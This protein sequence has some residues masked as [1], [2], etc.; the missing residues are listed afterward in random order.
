MQFKKNLASIITTSCHKLTSNNK[1]CYENSIKQNYEN[2]EFLIFVNGI[3]KNEYFKLLEFLEKK[4]IYNHKIKSLYSKSR[5]AIGKARRDLLKISN[6]E[7]IIFLDSDD[8]PS[9]NLISKKVEISKFLIF[10]GQ[11]GLSSCRTT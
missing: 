4:N 5:V 11:I 9:K 8:I 3:D 2:V 6:G 10:Q 1:S 7:Y